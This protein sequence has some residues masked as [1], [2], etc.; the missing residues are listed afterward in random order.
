M[1]HEVRSN[2][3]L[4][5]ITHEVINFNFNTFR[6]FFL[7]RPDKLKYLFWRTYRT[8][9]ILFWPDIFTGDLTDHR[10]Y[11]YY[12]FLW[13]F[14]W[15]FIWPKYLK[16]LVINIWVGYNRVIYNTR[17]KLKNRSLNNIYDLLYI[18]IINKKYQN[19]LFTTD[20]CYIIFMFLLCI[21]F[22]IRYNIIHIFYFVS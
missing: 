8:K 19:Q 21:N 16:S 5:G 9:F 22:A 17:R 13:I 1:V 10:L 2:E 3:Y 4:R 15:I 18:K 20:F 6:E 14:Y 12:L 7:W 11:C